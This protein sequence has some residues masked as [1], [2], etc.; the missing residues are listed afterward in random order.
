VPVVPAARILSAIGS[1][2]VTT[3]SRQA[4]AVGEVVPI[5]VGLETGAGVLG[6]LALTGGGEVRLN[7]RT[8][9]R[10]ADAREVSIERGTI[11]IDSGARG[12]SVIVRTPV[13]IVRDV[14]TRFEVGLVDGIWRVRVREGSVRFER[15]DARQDAD[16]GAELRVRGDGSFVK[17]PTST[18]GADWMWIVRAAPPFHVEGQTLAAFLDWVARESGRRIELADDRIRRSSAR[19]ILHGSIEG[20][21]VDEAMDVILPTC[22]LAHR[23]DAQRVIVSPA[24]GSNGGAR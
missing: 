19:T 22:G 8:V 24:E 1:I 12:G 17:R 10:F 5:G 18:Y 6:T 14:G 2:E 21:T 9:V 7:Q 20:L 13:G 3:G 23:L 15:G 11:Y 16:S 4:V